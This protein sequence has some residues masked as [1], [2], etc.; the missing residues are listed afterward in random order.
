MFEGDVTVA[1][2]CLPVNLPAGELMAE[3]NG[4]SWALAGGVSWGT[5]LSFSLSISEPAEHGV[6]TQVTGAPS[7]CWNWTFYPSK[8]K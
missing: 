3:C 5:H 1:A 4:M 2:P 7:R 8:R 6:K